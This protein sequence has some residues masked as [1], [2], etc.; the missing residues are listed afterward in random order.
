MFFLIE[1]VPIALIADLPVKFHCQEVLETPTELR[2]DLSKQQ[3]G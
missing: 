3:Y 1:I 2:H